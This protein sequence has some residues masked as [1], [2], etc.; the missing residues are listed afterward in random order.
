MG[1]V[2]FPYPV[3]PPESSPPSDMNAAHEKPELGPSP[4][5]KGPATR[6]PACSCDSPRPPFHLSANRESGLSPKFPELPRFSGSDSPD[7]GSQGRRS[8]RLGRLHSTH[9]HV[10]RN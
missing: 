9:S 7:T 4:K 10:S 6:A 1:V 2:K 3:L 8:N 5:P